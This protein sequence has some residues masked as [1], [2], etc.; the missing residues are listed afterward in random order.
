M[1]LFSTWARCLRALPR[2]AVRPQEQQGHAP[3][4]G[5]TL[6]FFWLI[7][8]EGGFRLP[9]R[10]LWPLRISL[11][12]ATPTLAI[13]CLAGVLQ[14]AYGQ[15]GGVSQLIANLQAQN[16]EVRRKAAADLGALKDPRAVAPLITA[17]EATNNNV[18]FRSSDPERE[19]EAAQPQLI[20]ARDSEVYVNALANIGEPAI[21]P[22]I[23]EL[24]DPNANGYARESASD[25]LVKIGAPALNPLIAAMNSSEP[26]Y[27]A[28]GVPSRIVMILG[29]IKD[30]RAVEPLIAIGRTKQILWEDQLRHNLIAAFGN[31]GAPS[32]APLIACLKDPDQQVRDI[33]LEALV[34]IGGPAVDPLIAALTNGGANQQTVASGRKSKKRKSEPSPVDPI[35][36]GAVKALGEI[37]DPRAIQPLAATLQD[38][39]SGLGESAIEAL[40]NIGPPAVEAL[41]AALHGTGPDLCWRAEMQLGDIADPRAI[42]PLIAALRSPG[43][44]VH[45]DEETGRRS[46]NRRA[47]RAP[48]DPYAEVREGAAEA[49]GKILRKTIDP[50]VTDA[51]V[52]SLHDPNYMVREAAAGALGQ[53][54]GPSMVGPL[55]GVLADANS[56]VRV[57]AIK[58]LG[59]IGA[60]AVE[61]LAKSLE[62]PDS[63]VRASAVEVL[64]RIGEPA[65]PA[66][67]TAL[68]STDSKVR[69]R[70]AGELGEIKDPRAVG[71]FIA[72]VKDPDANVRSA[73]V[74]SLGR[75]HDSRAVEPLIAA[76]QDSDPTVRWRA[77]EQLGEMAGPRSV[78]AL[79]AALR[80]HDDQ[81]IAGAMDFFVRR[82]DPGS[83]DALIEALN[84]AGDSGTAEILLNSSNTKLHDAAED[85]ASKYGYQV[86]PTGG[87]SAQ[88]GSSR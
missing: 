66:L 64:G 69:L 85:W 11:R 52:A 28:L 82:G 38:P 39:N 41:I 56:G 43:W 77:A 6:L 4:R 55:A 45:R 51:L 40:G 48:K 86:I 32:V 35:R 1:G 80:E 7:Y 71:P 18:Y 17:L 57:A 76:M 8:S 49:L 87:K 47:P 15:T 34:G 83:E 79:L 33:A 58:A 22:L 26:S 73:A 19:G 78:E 10:L 5:K 60:P 75:M 54:K 13:L 16:P 46:R 62:S 30:P 2:P 12:R 81:L 42:A 72:A 31:I 27:L 37:K 36:Q 68:Q 63:G 3:P 14:T 44:N 70:A 21:Q 20:A 65:V 25:A 50:S 61:P 29:R 88:W 84:K 74:I 53:I 67:I 9:L 24:H 23:G 59:N